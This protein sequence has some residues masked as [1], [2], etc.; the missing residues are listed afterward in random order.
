MHLTDRV[1]VLRLHVPLCRTVRVQLGCPLVALL[2]SATVLVASRKTVLSIRVSLGSTLAVELEGLLVTLRD[3]FSELIRISK[4]VLCT[5]LESA[6]PL[7]VRTLSLGRHGGDADFGVRGG[8]GL[9][10]F[11]VAVAGLFTLKTSD[12]VVPAFPT[13]EL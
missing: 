13:V 11:A 6:Q 4:L 3:A 5:L 10:A 7:P 8:V 12:Q 9:L 1:V 2:A